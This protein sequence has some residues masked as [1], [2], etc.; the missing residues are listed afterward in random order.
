MSSPCF[1]LEHL[2]RGNEAHYV[3]AFLSFRKGKLCCMKLI[4]SQRVLILRGIVTMIGGSGICSVI[5]LSPQN[6][7]YLLIFMITLTLN[8]KS[9]RHIDFHSLGRGGIIAMNLI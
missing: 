6:I 7:V 3:Y 5:Q 8:I 4:S 9:E 1:I 2:S